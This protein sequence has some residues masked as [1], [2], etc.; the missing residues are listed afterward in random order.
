MIKKSDVLD[1]L[2]ELGGCDAKDDY[3]KGYD[4]YYKGYDDAIDLIESEVLR[5]KET[6]FDDILQDMED[7]IEKSK[8]IVF[9]FE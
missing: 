2:F 3:Y 1:I 5:L 8:I 9:Y 6:T 4:D 7:L